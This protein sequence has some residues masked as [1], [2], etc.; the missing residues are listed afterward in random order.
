MIEYVEVYDKTTFR[1]LGV[2]DVF[3]SV[4]WHTCYYSTGDFE[5][6]CPETESNVSLLEIG[7]WVKVYGKDTVGMI[8]SVQTTFDAQEGR[9]L[10]VTGRMASAILDRRIVYKRPIKTTG[11]QSNI[12]YPTIINGN[13]QNAIRSLINDCFISPEDTQRKYSGL[14][15]EIG[16][17]S[18]AVLTGDDGKPAERQITYKGLLEYVE[19]L[20]QEYNLGA[21]VIFKN[22]KLC[23]YLYVGKNNPM[24]FSTEFDNLTSSEHTESDT[25]YKNVALVAGEEERNGDDSTKRQTTLIFGSQ[26]SGLERR[27]VYIDASSVS[28]TYEDDNGNEQTYDD[29]T[30]QSMLR[31]YGKNELAG[32]KKINSVSGVINITTT[33]YEIGKEISLGDIVKI[34]DTRKGVFV[35]TRILEAT[36]V[37]DENGYSLDLVYGE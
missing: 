1:M 23:Y 32:M 6:Y 34:Q 28:K 15:V 3:S 11:E 25:E 36:E 21:K 16:D 14:A 10:V 9:M 30:Y 8:E 7:R 20:L 26:F 19:S 24:I 29:A 2:V 35:E 13:V 31:S 17:V 37:Q 12:V 18:S 27:E 22:S 4:I 5:I 33:G